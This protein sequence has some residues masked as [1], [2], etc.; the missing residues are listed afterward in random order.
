MK[1]Y[2]PNTTKGRR[3]GWE[4]SHGVLFEA[5]AKALQSCFM[6]RLDDIQATPMVRSNWAFVKKPGDTGYVVPKWQVWSPTST[7]IKTK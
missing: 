2:T 6:D 5:N 7:S 4:L 3:I 1:P